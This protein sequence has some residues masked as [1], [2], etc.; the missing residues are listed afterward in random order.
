MKTRLAINNLEPG[1]TLPIEIEVDNTKCSEPVSAIRVG[2]K[3]Y[4]NVPKHH[5]KKKFKVEDEE[6]A[7][8]SSGSMA[9]N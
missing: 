6:I 5:V 7:F 3:R 9:A 2:L 1:T 8:A 4:V